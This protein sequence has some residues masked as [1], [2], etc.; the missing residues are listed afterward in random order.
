MT[1]TEATHALA[2]QART[3][4]PPARPTGASAEPMRL[5]DAIAR[6]EPTWVEAVAVV[7]AVCA[8]LLPGEA[9]PALET[10][11]ISPAGAVSF[12]PA[13]ASDDITA[14]KAIGGLLGGILSSGDCPMPVWDATE[15][16]RRAPATIGT[17]RSFGAALTCVLESQGPRELQ[18]YAEAARRVGPRS[19]RAA[20]APF[21]ATGLTA[22]AVVVLLM[23]AMGG[24]GAGISVGA[25][26]A[27]RTL[28]PRP[29]PLVV[30]ATNQGAPR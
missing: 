12:P 15:R 6:V 25:L 21:H 16:A 17:A 10:I 28:G 8:R 19:A 7:Q 26:V 1:L 5:V 29:A 18:Q 22:R 13:G 24:V 30:L 3:A 27:A 9:V 20:T 14:V 23:V 2:R 11:I 4:P